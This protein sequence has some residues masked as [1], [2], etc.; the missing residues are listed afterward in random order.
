MEFTEPKTHNQNKIEDYK[1]FQINML[2]L[3]VSLIIFL[4]FIFTLYYI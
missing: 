4:W 3:F 1:N 2:Q